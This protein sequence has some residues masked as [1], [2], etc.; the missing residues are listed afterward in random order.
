VADTPQKNSC[1]DLWEV[2]YTDI[3]T[4]TI[5]LAK[6][7]PGALQLTDTVKRLYHR[8]E[9]STKRFCHFEVLKSLVYNSPISIL[10]G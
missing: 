2:I 10:A 5:R 4:L 9:V 7:G 6:L 1:K 8:T 3:Y